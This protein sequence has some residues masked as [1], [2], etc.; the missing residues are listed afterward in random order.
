MIG[1]PVS[2]CL[3]GGLRRGHFFA[4]ASMAVLIGGRARAQDAANSV[5][6]QGATHA[7]PSPRRFA[8]VLGNANYTEFGALANSLRDA[9]AIRES[10][11]RLGFNVD[12][13]VDL[14]A[15]TMRSSIERFAATLREGDLAVVF[16]SGHGVSVDGTNYLVP[17]DFDASCGGRL[18]DA[19]ED[20][21]VSM[22][23]LLGEIEAR[24][25]R[26]VYFFDA[27]RNNP[28]SRAGRS[29]S[30]HRTRGVGRGLTVVSGAGDSLIAFA[31]ADGR[32][33]DD[34]DEGTHSPFTTALLRHIADPIDV[35]LMVGEVRSEV[36]NA[37]ARSQLPW[38]YESL[39]SPLYLATGA[40][41][42]QSPVRP[43]A[44][45]TASAA[46]SMPPPVAPA[47]TGGPAISVV[48][49]TRWEPDPTW[50]RPPFEGRLFFGM[51]PIRENHSTMIV[52]GHPTR[53]VALEVNDRPVS[54]YVDGQRVHGEMTSEGT[55][56]REIH[57]IP[58]RMS[59]DGVLQLT[60]S[61]TRRIRVRCF[62]TVE[63]DALVES[64]GG[65]LD[66]ETPPQILRP[67]CP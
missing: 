5:T 16:Y 58:P 53:W 40:V 48:R 36:F 46:P 62:H 11:T 63:G 24:Q 1:D 51:I 27:C 9:R 65:G 59:G 2:R 37:S 67:T 34:G 21:A 39:R 31:T 56:V 12:L 52:Q 10:L 28:C 8:L 7:A 44:S 13:A 55:G 17:V 32:T 42:T 29:R 19:L 26:G 33:A 49:Q 54:V 47:A 14:D 35:R 60:P 61:A 18:R 45:V 57:L 23:W 22:T 38:T 15:R 50:N 64:S 43:T 6:G 30:L 25:A 41:A 4:L 3:G 20:R 66:R